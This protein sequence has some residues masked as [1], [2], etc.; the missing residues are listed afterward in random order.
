VQIHI[1]CSKNPFRLKT[2]RDID[3]QRAYFAQL[4]TLLRELVGPEAAQTIPAFTS[5]HV[6][7]MEV[8]KDVRRIY[9][10]TSVD[11]RCLTVWQSHYAIRIYL[12]KMNAAEYFRVE[13][14]VKERQPLESVLNDVFRRLLQDDKQGRVG[15]DGA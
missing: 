11:L 5:W 8:N 1:R 6:D 7:R 3:F 13:C 12:K 9:P 2:G 10:L 4:D 15:S 14:V